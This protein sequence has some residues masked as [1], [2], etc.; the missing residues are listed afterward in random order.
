MIEGCREFQRVV[1]LDE[2]RWFAQAHLSTVYA[3]R[4]MLKEA[5]AAAEKAHALA[6]WD[7]PTI[8][9]LAG[10]LAR[11]GEKERAE[12]L[13]RQLVTVPEIDPAGVPLLSYLV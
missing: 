3:L 1:E 9:I 13:L 5:V 10:I 6:P 7:A 4:G 8:G 12:V 11:A 2:N